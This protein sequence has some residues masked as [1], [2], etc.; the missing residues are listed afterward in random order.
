MRLFEILTLTTLLVIFVGALVPKIK[1]T[2]WM[3][4]LF[5]LT[6]LFILLHLLIE[7]YRWQMLFP[8]ILTSFLFLATTRRIFFGIDKKRKSH[9]RFRKNLIIAGIVLRLLMLAI[10]ITCVMISPKRKLQLP[11]ELGVGITRIRPADGMV[12]VYVPAG[13]FKMGAPGLEWIR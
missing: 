7:G 2:R 12:M 5:V 1:K 10:T 4:Y 11:K 13:E 3:D 9:S 6:I 8:Y